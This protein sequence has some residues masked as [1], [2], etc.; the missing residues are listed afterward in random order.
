VRAKRHIL[1][2]GTH[3]DNL[4][5]VFTTFWH[6]SDTATPTPT[7]PSPTSPPTFPTYP[8]VS[9][10][11]PSANASFTRDSA[12]P[13]LIVSSVK[14]TVMEVRRGKDNLYF[15]S[16]QEELSDLLCSFFSYYM[17]EIT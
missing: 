11:P 15:S 7:A 17:L 2:K 4:L 9:I 16:Q 3:T 12:G 14:L 5:H 6:L 1:Q 13:P 10:S 8:G